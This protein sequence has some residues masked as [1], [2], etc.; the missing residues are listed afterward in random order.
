MKTE[1]LTGLKRLRHVDLD[2]SVG[3]EALGR[4]GFHRLPLTDGVAVLDR[5]TISR[6]RNEAE[7]GSAGNQ[8]RVFKV[9]RRV[10]G[11]HGFAGLGVV[12]RA[13]LHGAVQVELQRL[14][15]EAEHLEAVANGRAFSVAAGLS[16]VI[17][18]KGDRVVVGA[19]A[20]SQRC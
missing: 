17:E 5:Q 3:Q 6:K 14:R 8:R 13:Q 7:A 2:G 9:A 20:E 12:G 19:P 4:L 1:E 11:A 18:E 15:R 16:G 10:K